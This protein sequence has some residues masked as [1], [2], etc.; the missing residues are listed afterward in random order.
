MEQI[1][2]RYNR[3]WANLFLTC[4]YYQKY[5]GMSGNVSDVSNDLSPGQHSHGDNSPVPNT[6][7]SLKVEDIGL[8]PLIQLKTGVFAPADPNTPCSNQYPTNP[9]SC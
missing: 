3:T 7:K 5:Y 8:H 1:F 6:L 9:D 2:N 4:A